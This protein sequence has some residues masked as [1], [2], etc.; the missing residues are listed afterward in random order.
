MSI[1]YSI[2]LF[3]G[4]K[5]YILCDSDTGYCWNLKPYSGKGSTVD[6]TVRYLI[7]SL[8]NKGYSLYMDNFYISVRLAHQLTGEDWGTN[9][10]GTM[11]KHRGEPDVIKQVTLK[12]M[13]VGERLSRHNE[14]VMVLAWKAKKN[15]I[16]KMLTSHHQDKMTTCTQKAA[17]HRE[18]LLVEKPECVPFYNL[19]MN[20]VDCLDQNIGYYPCLRKTTK[21]TKKFVVYLMQIATFNA[22]VLFKA[23]TGSTMHHMDFIMSV[24]RSWTNWVGPL[25]ID[26]PLPPPEGEGDGEAEGEGDGE[27]EGDAAGGADAHAPNDRGA[28]RSPSGA[29]GD[30]AV[31]AVEEAGGEE[32]EEAHAPNDGGARRRTSPSPTRAPVMDPE[33]RLDGNRTAHYLVLIDK[34]TAKSDGRHYCRVCLRKAETLAAQRGGRRDNKKT[35]RTRYQCKQCL[36]A[37]CPGYCDMVYHT[38]VNYAN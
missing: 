11:R 33:T 27:A 29:L 21:W 30:V 28:R 36:V 9:V 10:C 31:V 2:Y 34:P 8:A 37:L 6:S 14:T 13:E 4:I 23:R 26:V 15:K 12:S 7:S 16:V 38:K 24:C 32:D 1:K 19:G 35:P 3:I 20:A 22:Y 5:S 25:A 18:P 17:G